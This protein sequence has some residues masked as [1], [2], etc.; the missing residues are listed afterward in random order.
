MDQLAGLLPLF[1]ILAVFWFIVLRPARK[2]Q[3]QVAALQ[4]SL[5]VGAR[6]MTA[7][8]MHATVAGIEGAT[9]QLDAAPGVTLTFDRRAV[10]QV[11]APVDDAGVAQEGGAQAETDATDE[12]NPFGQDDSPRDKRA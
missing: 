3:Q 8:G 10:T 4:A 6:V 12:F 7:S 5:A 2:K 1:A 9:V 11:L